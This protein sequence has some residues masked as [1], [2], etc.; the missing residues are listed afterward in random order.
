MVF[1]EILYLTSCI[2]VAI[3]NFIIITI[4]TAANYVTTIFVVTLSL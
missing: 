2:S 1:V 4:V 3:F